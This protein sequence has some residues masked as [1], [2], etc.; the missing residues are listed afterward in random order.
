MGDPHKQC[1]YV[2]TVRCGDYAQCPYFD[3][4]KIII[5]PNGQI[6]QPMHYVNC[7]TSGIVYMFICPCGA[8]Y[9]GKTK[10]EFARRI[11]DH[12]YAVSIGDLYSPI[13]KHVHKHKIPGYIRRGEIGII[14]SCA[15]RLDGYIALK[16]MCTLG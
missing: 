1:K 10:R 15:L 3:T 5:L 12:M 2:G 7:K 14:K 4:R 6:W 13:G 8:F 9:I 16:D 11:Q